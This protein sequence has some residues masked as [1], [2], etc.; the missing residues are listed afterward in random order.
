MKKALLVIALSVIAFGLIVGGIFGAI[1]LDQS[2]DS[3][4]IKNVG[5]NIGLVVAMFLG[6]VGS[7]IG[8]IASFFTTK[9]KIAK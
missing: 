2:G 4:T 3:I 5:I 9:T 7:G 6:G 8:A 1:N